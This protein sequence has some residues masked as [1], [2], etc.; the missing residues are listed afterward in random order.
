MISD[1]LCAFEWVYITNKSNNAGSRTTSPNE[2]LRIRQDES[3]VPN[4]REREQSGLCVW[5]RPVATVACQYVSLDGLQ[6]VCS[7]VQ[8]TLGRPTTLSMGFCLHHVLKNG[9]CS[10]ERRRQVSLW[11]LWRTHGMGMLM[12]CPASQRCDGP[13]KCVKSV[14]NF[15]C[16]SK[17]TFFYCI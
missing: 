8:R 5:P 6:F 3:S 15:Q 9:V 4:C 13:K 2:C 12:L 7:A 11:R 16:G 10:L 17:N 1:N 14:M